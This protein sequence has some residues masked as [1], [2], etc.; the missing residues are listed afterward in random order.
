MHHIKFSLIEIIKFRYEIKWVALVVVLLL[1]NGCAAAEPANEPPPIAQPGQKTGT[2]ISLPM[3]V[4]L[5]C[6]LS[7]FLLICFLFYLFHRYA[8]HQFALAATTGNGGERS[9]G[10]QVAAR[11]LDPAVVAT[12]TSFTYSVVKEI[13]IGQQALECAVCLNGYQDHEALRLLPECSHVFHRDCL[14]E[15]LAL[16]VTCPVCRASLVPKPDPLSRETESWH[17]TKETTKGYVSI[18]LTELKHDLPPVRK[19]SRSCSMGERRSKNVERYTLRLSEEMQNVLNN[20][21]VNPSTNSN[22]AFSMGSDTKLI[23]LRSASV[24][25]IRGSDCFN[26]II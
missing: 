5:A 22:V 7:A 10:K 26:H 20:L 3:A 6:L 1:A 25:S 15:W 16:H 2:K 24:N 12:F 18:Q 4:V 13:M 9:L 11:G 8:E 17:S 14:D 21:T 23:N 19:I